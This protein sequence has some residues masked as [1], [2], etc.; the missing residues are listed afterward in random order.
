[1]RSILF[2]IFIYA[3]IISVI[4]FAIYVTG[5]AWGL[6]GLFL[7]PGKIKFK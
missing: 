3:S 2:A 7:L 5:S 4:A 6:L 1:M